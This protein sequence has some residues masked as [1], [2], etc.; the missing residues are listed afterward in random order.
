MPWQALPGGADPGPRP[1]G[2]SLD[3]VASAL[4]APD[5]AVLATVFGS[6]EELVGGGVAAHARP[7]SL[8]DGVLV[9]AVEQPVWATQLRWASPV[10]VERVNQVVGRRVVD[11]VVLRVDAPGSGPPRP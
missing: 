3:R 2:A 6:W 9:I 5:A 10:L 4:G 7:R 11:R 8:R 1:V